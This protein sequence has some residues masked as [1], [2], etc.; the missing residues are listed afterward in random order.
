MAITRLPPENVMVSE[1]DLIR[2]KRGRR[3]VLWLLLLSLAFNWWQWA[4]NADLADQ[5]NVERHQVLVLTGMIDQLK[6]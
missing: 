3:R 1:L 4:N 5:L 6:R 2:V